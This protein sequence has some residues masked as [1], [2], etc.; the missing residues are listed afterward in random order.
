MFIILSMS[1]L[2][3]SA[4]SAFGAATIVG[5]I[6]IAKIDGLV[7]D[8]AHLDQHVAVM[9]AYECM[10]IY[11]QMHMHMCAHALVCLSVCMYVCLPACLYV[12]LYVC[13]S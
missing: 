2:S 12:G 8:S 7:G 4:A 3:S 5:L 6:V 9:R 1:D 13:L 10:Q 11:L